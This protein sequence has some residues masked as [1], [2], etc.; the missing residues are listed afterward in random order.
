[1]VSASG[2]MTSSQ[3]NAGK[4][5]VRTDR[6]VVTSDAD[7]KNAVETL[8][9][10][11]TVSDYVLLN[12]DGGPY[13]GPYGRVRRLVN[14]TTKT[15]LII[16]YKPRFRQLP[17][18]R[19]AVVPADVPG[20]WRSELARILRAFAPHGLAIVEVAIDF[21]RSRKLNAG[22]IR[23]HVKFGKSRMRRNSK[24]PKAV[25]LGAPASATFLRCYPKPQVGGFRVETQFNSAYLKKHGIEAPRD[26]L[27]LSPLLAKNLGFFD[28]DWPK[29]SRYARRHLRHPDELLQMARDRRQSLNTMLKFLRAVIPNVNRFLVPMKINGEISQA[30]QEWRKDSM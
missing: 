9:D 11:R 12:L 21:P 1:V 6:V 28:L 4:P 18:M 2:R 15:W 14:D 26:F 23:R 8:S 30:L 27:R 7:L 13:R 17:L 16:S 29:L 5:V 3:R 20:L 25:W 24:Y 22:F 19:V 10:F